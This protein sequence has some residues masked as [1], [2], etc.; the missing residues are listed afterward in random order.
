MD[1][2]LRGDKLT[3]VMLEAEDRAVGARNS[4]PLST[5]GRLIIKG[6]SLVCHF[7]ESTRTSVRSEEDG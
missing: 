2:I 5:Y 4:Q 7:E 6:H 1:A 3:S